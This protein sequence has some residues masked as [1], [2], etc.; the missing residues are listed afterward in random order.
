M[1]EINLQNIEE[2]IFFDKK[3]YSLLPEFRHLFDQWGLSKR[4]PGMSTLGPRV[5]LELLNSLEKSHISKLEEYFGDIIILDRVDHKLVKNH[6]SSP[7]KLA[8]ELCLFS[9]YRDCCLHRDGGGVRVTFW[10]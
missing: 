6:E 8:E 1:M 7:E 4:V 9:G 10:R 3:I 2:Y 5:V